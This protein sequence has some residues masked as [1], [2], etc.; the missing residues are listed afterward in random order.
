M[1]SKRKRKLIKRAVPVQ[2]VP[3]LTSEQAD[4]L[5]AHWI[6]TAQELIG[7]AES[8]SG[9]EALV[10]LLKIGAE[11]LQQIVNAAREMVPRM[12]SR[13]L[14]IAAKAAESEIYTTG[15]VPPREMLVAAH[16]P[17]VTVAYPL[18]LPSSVDHRDALPPVRSQGDRGACVAFAAVAVRE[19]LETAAGALPDEL[20]LSEQFVYWYCKEQDQ[21]PD[22][23]GTY[24]RLG[25]ECLLELGT[26]EEK[27]WPYVL[28]QIVG[29]EGQGPPPREALDG[30]GIWRV[31][32]II[33]LNAGDVEDLKTCLA[34]GKVIA[35]SIPVFDSWY[36][37][38]AVKRYGKI[39]M[40][41]PGEE[42][43]GGHAMTLVGYQDDEE[44][45]GG[46]YF[47]VRN[48]WHPWGYESTWGESYGTIPY[49]YLQ[50]HC[51]AALS[52]D[53]FT[54]AD[55]YIRDNEADQGQVPSKA[56]YWNSPDIWL[57][58]APDAGETHQN[59][60]PGQPNFL[61]LRVHNR[62]QA[63]AYNVKAHLYTCAL[64]PCIWPRNWELLHT[65]DVPLV[66]PGTML[67]GP[68]EWQPQDDMLYCYLVR[69]ESNDDPIQHD[70]SVQ[71]DNNI[72]QK[73][74]ALMDLAPGEEGMLR[75]VMHGIWGRLSRLTLDVDRMALP[76]GTDLE[77]ETASRRF[78]TGL[79]PE[80]ATLEQ[81]RQRTSAHITAAEASLENLEVRS[82]EEGKVTVKI[83]LSENAVLGSQYK[84][85]LTQRLGP[86]VI[87]KLTCL[88]N[89]REPN[90]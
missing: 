50:E 49:A 13:R 27:A 37:S 78:P 81:G 80:G 19:K 30:A 52:A 83:R 40:P 20:D 72:A 42:A 45:P 14:L 82:S 76:A 31:S 46:G 54:Q 51:Y 23:S 34:E 79:R 10:S 57:R 69:L 11:Q 58:N 64:S 43:D 56:A 85:V 68:M 75:F 89:V 17:Y 29:N 26:P 8:E 62:G 6:Q 48:S 59:P 74:V 77:V 73:N 35:F 39:T 25:L 61:Y 7:I 16:S 66:Q 22:V 5:R 12:Y 3:N 55:I 44:A 47:I 21:L 70:W 32:R 90:A 2:E 87:G 24:T 36:Y 65:L 71:W 38:A 84:A 9:R 1:A 60:I 41:L 18:E 53:R 15:S 63:T 33:D 28:E 4:T 88:I 67:I 86:L